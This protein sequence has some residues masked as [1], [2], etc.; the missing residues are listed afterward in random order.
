MRTEEHEKI[1]KRAKRRGFVLQKSAAPDWPYGLANAHGVVMAFQNLGEVAAY[2]KIKDAER[3]K[4][5]S[6]AT[7]SREAPALLPA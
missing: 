4:R 5:E 6:E 3:K 7:I 1:A 2:L